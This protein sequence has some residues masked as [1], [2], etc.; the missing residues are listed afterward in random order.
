MPRVSISRQFPQ[1]KFHLVLLPLQPYFLHGEVVF[2]PPPD[3]FYEH[4]IQRVS[5]T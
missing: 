3:D 4:Q 1:L 5:T 2:T